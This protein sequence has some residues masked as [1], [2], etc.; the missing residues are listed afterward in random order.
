MD[1]MAF[2]YQLYDFLCSTVTGWEK[3]ADWGMVRQLLSSSEEG[4]LVCVFLCS[5]KGETETRYRQ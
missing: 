4:I 3:W 5:W 1:A 2:I